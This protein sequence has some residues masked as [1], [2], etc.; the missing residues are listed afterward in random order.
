MNKGKMVKVN[1]IKVAKL[2]VFII[3][4]LLITSCTVT[5][6]TK[7]L[8]VKTETNWVAYP[9]YISPF[10]DSP[11]PIG[12]S[13]TQIRTAYNLPNSGGLGSTIAIIDAFDTP[14]ILN[15]FNAFSGNYSLPDNTTG[16]FIVYKM[17]G[18]SEPPPSKIGWQLETCL[19]VEWAHAIAPN[20]TILLVE[21]VSDRGIDLLAGVDVAASYPTVVAVSMSWGR[22]EF[23]NE[24]YYDG[25]FNKPGITFFAS[26]GDDGSSVMWPAVSSKVVSVG[27]TTLNLNVDGTVISEVAWQNSSGGL[28]S[29][30]DRP[31]YQTSYG[32]NYSKRAVPDVSYNANASTGVSVY[33]GTWWKV[34][35]TSAGAPQWAAINALKLSVTSDNLYNRAKS[36]YS[37]YFQDIT[38]GAN[39]VYPALTGYDLVTGLG[40]PL[41]ANFGTE[42]TISPISGPSNG[43]ITINGVGFYP[44]SSVNISYINPIDASWVPIVNDLLIDSNNFSYPFNAPDLLQNNE[45]GDTQPKFDSIIIRV[46]DINNLTYNATVP[47]TEWRR[48]LTQIGNSKA[49]GLY[50]NNT[51]LSTSLFVQNNEGISVIGSW[52]NPGTV[53]LLWDNTTNIGLVSADGTGFFNTTVKVPTTTAGPHILT[54]N[55][56]GSYFCINITRLPSIA[57]DYSDGWHLTDFLINLIP[58]YVVN[59]TFYSIN[60]GPILNI[61][62]N[63]QP[64]ITTQG[65]NNTLEYWST[66]NVYG[67]ETMELPHITLTGIKLDK[68]PPTVSITIASNY[69]SSGETV[70]FNAGNSSDESGIASYSWDFGDG[71]TGSGLTTT[72][73]YFNPGTYAATLTLQDSAGNM[74]TAAVTMIVQTLL[75]APNS[76]PL[77]T[78]KSTP[79]ASPL[80]TVAPSAS[81]ANTPTVPPSPKP[82]PQVSEFNIQVIL[83][84]LITSTLALTLIFRK[85]HDYSKDI[86]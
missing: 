69:V 35:G 27:G 53:S 9:M 57:N 56:G 4:S 30:V 34:G 8:I 55:D 47:Y 23:F 61:T 63:G 48:G 3:C 52:F 39:K 12:Y 14:D 73:T 11:T 68:T 81:P 15:Y 1:R 38:V 2:L 84:L 71:F 59:E 82:T 22:T 33:N 78:S 79:T 45:V 58:D 51:D 25:H 70:T 36:A 65:D 85:R 60:G 80:P 50:G 72:H 54:I 64:K 18:V 83:I 46:V 6:G 66:W 19:D 24:V 49:T 5:F 67:T 10:A 21:A 41:T 17:P 40:S 28:S 7:L 32:L 13:V 31:K 42:V 76:S 75:L 44:G 20:A 62:N 77:P 29:Y 74:Q 16:N 37:S 86:R 26:S 43:S